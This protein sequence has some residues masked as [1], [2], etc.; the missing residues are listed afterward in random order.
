MSKFLAPDLLV[1]PFDKYQRY[2]L[3]SEVLDRL[4]QPEEKFEILEAG[5]FHGLSRKFLDC[6]LVVVADLFCGGDSLDLLGNA[7]VLP[8]PDRSFPVVMATDFLEHVQPERRAAALSELARTSSELVLI[9]AP[10]QYALAREAEQ[11]V[12]DFIQEWLGYE[13]KF[14]KEHLQLA[15]PDLAQTESELVKAGFDTV[16]LP[17]GQI[18]RWLLMMLAYYFFEAGPSGM[19][20]RKELSRFYNQHYFWED[21]AE[22][23]YRHLI[24]ASRTRLREKPDALNDLIARKRVGVE[25]DYERFRLWLELFKTG[26]LSRA[27]AKILDLESEL[28]DKDQALEHLRAYVLELEDFHRKVKDSVLYR[29]Y[30]KIFKGK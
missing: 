6:D 14:L 13:H 19:E 22:P 1:S 21:L 30:A 29:A 2:R 7:E 16:I 23:A 27:K 18:E 8:F 10:F 4:R 11:M 20:V 25:P 26:E 28:K 12:F 5:G 9:S 3:L 24:V 15:A 17:N